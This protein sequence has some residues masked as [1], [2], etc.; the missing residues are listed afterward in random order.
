MKD[1]AYRAFKQ[2]DYVNAFN[3]AKLQAIKGSTKHMTLLGMLYA[4]GLG[5]GKCIDQA[6]T[7]HFFFTIG[8]SAR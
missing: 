5:V 1:S 4:D 6:L 2:K 7:C 3:R 8:T